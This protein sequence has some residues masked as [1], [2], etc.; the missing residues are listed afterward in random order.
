MKFSMHHKLFKPVALAVLLATSAVTVHAQ[1]KKEEN[2]I[3]RKKSD[4]KEKL[5]IVVDGD[6][7]T[8]NG[9]PIDEFKDEDVEVL[10]RNVKNLSLS[11]NN[12]L[13]DVVVR[14]Y[15]NSKRAFLGV[16]SETVSEGAKISGITQHS[17]AD[18][19]GLK[20]GD[21]ITKVDENVL[22][23]DNSLYNIISKYK[24]TDKVKVTFKRDGKVQTVN[25]EL[26]KAIPVPPAPPT[27]PGADDFSFN[28]DSNMPNAWTTVTGFGRPKLGVEI[29]DLEEGKGV[30]VTDV[31]D[32]MAIAK[33]GLKEGDIITKVNDKE[34]ADVDAMKAAVREYKS[35]E[36]FK[37]E[38]TAVV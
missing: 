15:G 27:Y 19:A 6:K 28:F 37:I 2:I 9:K 1:Q 30:K 7:V 12:N 38:Y 32:G 24:P 18:K 3:I 4:S 23:D 17:A 26:G 21:I 13:R 14:G 31:E 5:T 36:S 35:G 22:S 11:V 20:E 16:T 10:R 33:A 29:Q 8:V 34:V 25:A